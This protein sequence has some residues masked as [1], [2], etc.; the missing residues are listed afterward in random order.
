MAPRTAQRDGMLVQ[1][2]HGAGPG[3]DGPRSR[4][5]RSLIRSSY[6][7]LDSC[8]MLCCD[9]MD[10]PHYIATHHVSMRQTQ[11]H[12]GSSQLQYIIEHTKVSSRSLL[13]HPCLQCDG[14]IPP[15]MLSTPIGWIAMDAA[16]KWIWPPYSKMRCPPLEDLVHVY[17][18]V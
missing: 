8:V 6:A 10:V 3:Q 1:D 5:A 7:T 12:T 17:H 15:P 11:G 2:D 4:G 18:F 13:Q 9:S 14:M 16:K